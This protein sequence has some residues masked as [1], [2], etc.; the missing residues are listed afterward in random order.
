[1]SEATWMPALIIGGAALA[2]GFLASWVVRRRSGSAASSLTADDPRRPKIKALEARR[3]K[4]YARLRDKTTTL[5]KTKRRRLE[6]EAATILRDLDALTESVG[7]EPQAKSR[8]MEAAEE[9]T[10]APEAAAQ[11]PR[12]AVRRAALVGFVSGVAASLL[13]S[14][15]IGWA[16][17]EATP[18]DMVSPAA[19][20]N[21]SE[22]ARTT[23]ATGQKAGQ[24]GQPFHEGTEELSA[25]IATQVE[26][27]KARMTA[28]PADLSAAKQ[29]AFLL[30]IN[31]NLVEAF[32]YSKKALEMSPD[33]PDGLYVQGV[34]RIR[35]GQV[36]Q[37]IELLDRVL[38]QYPNHLLAL[39][40]RGSALQRGGSTSQAIET[41]RRALD[42]AGGSHAEIER[43][44]AEAQGAVQPAAQT[45]GLPQSQLQP[46]PQPQTQPPAVAAAADATADG[47]GF[48]VRIELA[49]GASPP[50]GGTLFLSLRAAEGG[51][52]TAARK[53]INPGFPLELTLGQGDSMLGGPLPSSGTLT[54]R[55]DADGNALTHGEDD[56]S[57][58]GS[59]SAGGEKA[60]LRLDG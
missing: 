11:P 12:Q 37:A 14:T 2:I 28:N 34:V 15:L 27:L 21:T 6:D 1:M 49:P 38:E 53:V 51:P 56:L 23:A 16:G 50:P 36:Q 29:L 39:I 4:I 60:I 57:A 26:A 58:T 8:P 52:P 7:D 44:I 47:S 22:A 9:A 41:W 43:L 54:A 10:E 42:V 19:M 40:A 5:S 45:G 35:M 33:D 48:A 30:L 18:R 13:V 17:K 55:L 32:D 25:E 20:P 3:D 46:Q 59:A 31:G 24:P